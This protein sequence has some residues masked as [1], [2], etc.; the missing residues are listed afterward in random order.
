[1]IYVYET[2][3]LV[4]GH[5]RA[6]FNQVEYETTGKQR[7]ISSH[8]DN[9]AESAPGRADVFHRW[10]KLE[11]AGVNR[12]VNDEYYSTLHAAVICEH[13]NDKIKQLT[14]NSLKFNSHSYYLKVMNYNSD[15]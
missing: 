2:R 1:M 13:L 14:I 7:S 15:I 6:L 3:R 12:H 10:I 5:Q 4:S 9:V 8:R 11:S